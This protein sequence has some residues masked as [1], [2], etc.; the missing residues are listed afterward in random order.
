MKRFENGQRV[1]V[2]DPEHPMV[3]EV[4]TVRRLRKIDGGAWVEMDRDLPLD[5][6]TFPADD[7]RRNHALLYPDECERLRR[8]EVVR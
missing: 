1:R 4:G 3:G 7:P 8:V 5:L 2:S 6:R